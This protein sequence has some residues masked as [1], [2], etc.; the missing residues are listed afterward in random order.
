MFDD[1]A[2]VK[3]VKDRWNLLKGTQINSLYTFINETGVYLKYSQKENFNKWG[4]LYNYTWPNPVALGSY[5]SEVQ[6]MKD[7]LSQRINWMDTEINK[8]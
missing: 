3:K 4:V 2:F 8:L 6:Y 5:D 1:P 7:W